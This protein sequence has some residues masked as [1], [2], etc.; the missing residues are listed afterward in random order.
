MPP[1]WHDRWFWGAQITG[2]LVFLTGNFLS[3][4]AAHEAG[5]P[6]LRTTIPLRLVRVGLAV[7]ISSVLALALHRLPDL[8]TGPRRLVGGTVLGAALAGGT[9]YPLYRIASHPWRTDGSA[10]LA[11]SCLV[12]CLLDHTWIMLVWSL[13]Y[14]AVRELRRAS[15]R[16]QEALHEARLASEARYQMLVYQVNPHFLFNALNS[17][18]ALA[19]EDVGRARDMITQLA[20]FLRH[21]LVA[22]PF[23]AVPLREELATVEAYLA[24]EQVRHEDAL[25]VVFDVTPSAAAVP[26]PG[27]VVHPLVENALTHGFATPDA[28]LHLTIRAQCDEDRLVVEVRNSGRLQPAGRGSTGIGVRNIRERLA[29]LYGGRAALTLTEETGDVVARLVVPVATARHAA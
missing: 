16:E 18:R 2:W 9:W 7:V 23:D 12:P 25:R 1:P 28:V 24:V 20:A 26:V 11:G 6:D 10:P 8:R 27:F 15:A 13:L 17:V 5:D 4:L 22:R 21:T 14:V 3:A 19:A 29:H